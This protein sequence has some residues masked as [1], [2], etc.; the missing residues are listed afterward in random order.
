MEHLNVFDACDDKGCFMPVNFMVSFLAE[1]G[2]SEESVQKACKP[3]EVSKD[4][5]LPSDK[6]DILDLIPFA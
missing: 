6:I 1:H 5:F 3:I 4:L 2:V